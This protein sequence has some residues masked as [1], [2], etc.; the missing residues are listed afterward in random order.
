MQKTTIHIIG[1]HCKACKALIEDVYSE[2]PGVHSCNVNFETGQTVIE[3]EGSLDF[4]KLK[5]E[6][7]GLGDYKVTI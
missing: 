3:H 1:T 7:E 6:I 2:I 5:K 4:E